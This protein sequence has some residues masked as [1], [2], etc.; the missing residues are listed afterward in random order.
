VLTS[1]HDKRFQSLLIAMSFTDSSP[2][3]IAVQQALYALIALYVYG[4][5]RAMPYKVKAITTLSNSFPEMINIKN[6]L[7]HIAAGLLLSLYEV[8]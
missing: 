7:Q 8:R 4:S 6:G 3:S 2:S 1:V 5:V